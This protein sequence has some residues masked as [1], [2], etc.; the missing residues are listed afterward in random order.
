MRRSSWLAGTLTG[1]LVLLCAAAASGRDKAFDDIVHRLEAHYQ[2]RPVRFMGLASFLS[3]RARPEGVRKMRLAV[4]EDL[5]PSQSPPGSDFDSFLQDVVGSEFK[6]FV[7]VLS[8]RDGE[9]TYVYARGA[10]DSCELLVVNFGRDEASVIQM[11]MKPDAMT[12]WFDEPAREARH[13][14][15]DAEREP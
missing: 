10:G 12:D 7:R 13:S 11:R 9:Q 5:D 1:G 4:F 15:H 2:A 14:A 3:N 8:R 6:P